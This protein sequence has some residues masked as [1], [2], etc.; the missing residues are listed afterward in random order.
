MN[1]KVHHIHEDPSTLHVGTCP[2]RSYYIPYAD[3]K[4]AENGVSSRVI[5]L[6]GEW[7]FQYFDSY[8]DAVESDGTVD[9]TEEDM[10]TIPV[11]SCWQ[12]Y[13]YGRHHVHQRAVS[14]PLR[15]ALCPRGEP[16]RRLCT[17]ATSRSEDPAALRLSYLNFEGVDS[18][19]YR[20]DQ[21]GVCGLQPGFPLH[22]RV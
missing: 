19:F 12:N 17:C 1:L 8:K 4:E 11:P 16:L 9:F 14:L 6:N 13:G 2:N 20:V 3:E 18:C 5:S 7:A 15:P 10:D 22:Q 21:R